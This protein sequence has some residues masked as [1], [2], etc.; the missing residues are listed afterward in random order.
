[1]AGDATERGGRAVAGEI[2]LQ[3]RADAKIAGVVTRGLAEGAVGTPAAVRADEEPVRPRGDVGFH[4]ELRPEGMYRLH[5]TRFDRRNQRRMRVD[6]PIF[7]D[8]APQSEIGRV[9]G[10]EQLDGGG[11]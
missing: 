6:R 2:D 9:S 4:A 5:E 11:I 3:R 7:T 1:E 8:L 10:Q